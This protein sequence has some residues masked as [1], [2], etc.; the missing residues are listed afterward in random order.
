MICFHS[1]I[2]RTA[3]KD[4]LYIF[5]HYH[6]RQ[7]HKAITLSSIPCKLWPQHSGYKERLACRSSLLEPKPLFIQQQLP[8]ICLSTWFNVV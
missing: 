4:I 1:L 2:V 3:A 5:N 6:T 7:F 8:H